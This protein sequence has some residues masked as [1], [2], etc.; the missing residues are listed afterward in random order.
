[1]GL[2]T[3]QSGYKLERKVSFHQHDQIIIDG[4]GVAVDENGVALPDQPGEK[5]K[6]KRTEEE[7]AARKE[8][9][10][11]KGAK[12][13]EREMSKDRKCKVEEPIKNKQHPVGGEL[14]EQVS[15]KL[16]DIERERNSS[17]SMPTTP[18]APVPSS[19]LFPD[20]NSSGPQASN[21]SNIASVA[22]PKTEPSNHKNANTV[23]GHV[24][25]AGADNKLTLISEPV[26]RAR[27][28]KG[29][30]PQPPIVD[31]LVN[32]EDQSVVLR[33]HDINESEDRTRSNRNSLDN[34]S[35]QTLAK[36]LA[37]ECAKAYE[38]MESS[39]SKLTNDFSIGPFG[40]TPKT[41]K[42]SYR[43]PPAPALK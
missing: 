25:V 15:A 39:L 18:L 20:F 21:K 16:H 28:N 35:V 14:F 24:D 8:K 41:K 4:K 26:C 33:E 29:P 31:N 27:S 22:N 19:S 12:R 36:D 5:K 32:L 1:M 17:D 42:K 13:R 3:S 43:G 6:K 30:A 38:L 40:L 10:E 2:D 7:K 37:A 11:K 23:A 9:K 34:K